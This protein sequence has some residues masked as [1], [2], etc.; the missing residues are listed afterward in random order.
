MGA[1]VS[2]AGTPTIT[3]EG[4]ESLSGVEHSVMSDRIEA[5]TYAM[6]AA[7]AGGDVLLRDAPCHALKAMIEILHE[8]G[9]DAIVE[10]DGLRIRRNGA[11]LKAVDIDTGAA[12]WLPNRPAGSVHGADGDC[13]R[14]EHHSREYL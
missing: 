7:A 4:V 11:R 14:Q 13:R 6:A 2:G 12:S 1:K 9:V 8:A 5:G 3:I 10:S